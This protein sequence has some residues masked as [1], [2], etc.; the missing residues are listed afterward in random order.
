MLVLLVKSLRDGSGKASVVETRQLP[1]DPMR[2]WYI[3]TLMVHGKKRNG[4]RGLKLGRGWGWAGAVSSAK[5][6]TEGQC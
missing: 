5:S 1:A 4:K 6:K 2:S 3:L